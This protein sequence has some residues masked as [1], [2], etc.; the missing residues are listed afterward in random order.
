MNEV[1]QQLYARKSVRAFEESEIT[2]QE[3][4]AI[5][6]AAFE[7]PTAGNQQLYTILDITDLSLIHI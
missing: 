4:Q 1:L 2:P 7:A 3:K 6:R 5:L